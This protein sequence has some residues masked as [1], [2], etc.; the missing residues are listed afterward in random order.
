M[1]LAEAEASFKRGAFAAA[2]FVLVGFAIFASAPVLPVEA[3]LENNASPPIYNYSHTSVPWALVET[4]NWSY[5]EWL[6]RKFKMAL[7]QSSNLAPPAALLLITLA[8]SGCATAYGDRRDD[9]ESPLKGLAMI[10]GLATQVPEPKDF[11]KANRPTALGYVPIGPKPELGQDSRAP[12]TAEELLLL[13]KQLDAA[14][15][16]NSTTPTEQ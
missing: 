14:R 5:M 9:T 12:L 2:D 8:L 6:R 7:I 13:Q 4:R 1:D 16:Q 11:V 10:G 3:R 15:K